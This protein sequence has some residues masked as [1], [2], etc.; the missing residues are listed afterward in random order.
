M[1]K[2]SAIGMLWKTGLSPVASLYSS[3][4]VLY[5]GQIQDSQRGGVATVDRTVGIG[6]SAIVAALV[7][8]NP[9][10]QVLA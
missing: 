6:K 3:S 1:A 2:S 8:D 7:D 10:G 5:L 9:D 4:Q